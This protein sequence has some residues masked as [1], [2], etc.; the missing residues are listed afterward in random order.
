LG[1]IEKK[2]ETPSFGTKIA[3]HGA[4][5]TFAFKQIIMSD[6]YDKPRHFHYDFFFLHQR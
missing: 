1:Q 6:D 4:S 3:V 5:A 2:T